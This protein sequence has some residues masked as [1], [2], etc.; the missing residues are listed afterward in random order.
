MRT[1]GRRTN[2]RLVESWIARGR[3]LI[4]SAVLAPPSLIAMLAKDLTA[5]PSLAMNNHG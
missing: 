3:E 4:K 5:A 2:N 1:M